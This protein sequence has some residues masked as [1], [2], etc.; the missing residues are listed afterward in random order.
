[1]IFYSIH[2]KIGN[3]TL[4]DTPEMRDLKGSPTGQEATLKRACQYPENPWSYSPWG[5]VGLD[6]Y[7]VG[8]V[9]IMTDTLRNRSKQL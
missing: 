9:T 4:C 2:P 7:L 8:R 3:L 1:M 6:E 5:G